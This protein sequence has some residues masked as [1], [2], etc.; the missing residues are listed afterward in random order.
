MTKPKI[1]DFPP[2]RVMVRGPVIDPLC[3]ACS[4]GFVKRVSRQGIVERL[5]SLFYIYPFK[6]QLCG[7][8]FKRLQW[9]VRY[10]RVDQDR[11]E[12]NRI[13]TNFPVLLWGE[14]IEV[15]GTATDISMRGCTVTIN[16]Q[17][18]DGSILGVALKI[19]NQA[20][21]VI[22]EAAVLRNIQTNNAGI[23]FLRLQEN[24]RER[25]RGFI[26]GLL[27]GDKGVSMSQDQL[28]VDDYV[29]TLA[30]QQT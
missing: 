22:V 18:S 16:G 14:N 9:G 30:A 26:H 28:P 17:L 19:S 10:M 6:C 29:P 8:R 25:L 24:D 3:P 2:R 5:I 11:R 4:R 20:L 7:H 12:Y 23:E 13:A 21:P 1:E 27:S 15:E